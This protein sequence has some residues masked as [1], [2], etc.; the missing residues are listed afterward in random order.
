MSVVFTMTRSEHQQGLGP[1]EALK[2]GEPI[3]WHSLAA[4]TEF[5]TVF[6]S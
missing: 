5:L 2:S 3:Y 4:E 1:L 6:G